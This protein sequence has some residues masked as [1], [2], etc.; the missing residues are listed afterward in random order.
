[1]PSLPRPHGY[2]VGG[3]VLLAGSAAK[4]D[5]PDEPDSLEVAGGG[6][7]ASEPDGADSGV[8]SA[9]ESTVAG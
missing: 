4:P 1:M 2:A 8:L 7:A 6:V 9:A 3:L 5:E